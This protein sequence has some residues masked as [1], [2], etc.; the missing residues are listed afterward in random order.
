MYMYM[1]VQITSTLLILYNMYVHVSRLTVA[2]RVVALPIAIPIDRV[3][4]AGLTPKIPLPTVQQPSSPKNMT[5]PNPSD[6][7]PALAA[8]IEAH[9]WE[10]HLASHGCVQHVAPSL[11]R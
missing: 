1:Y 10:V 11:T 7:V 2:F 9:T 5:D 4:L 8:A 3:E 6:W